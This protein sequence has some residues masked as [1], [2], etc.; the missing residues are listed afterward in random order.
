MTNQQLKTIRD[1][2]IKANPEKLGYC[3]RGGCYDD[4][5][6]LQKHQCPIGLASVLLA[7][8]ELDN[9]QIG[10]VDSSGQ[11]G[12]DT[13]QGDGVDW[14]GVCWNLRQDDLTLQSDECISFLAELFK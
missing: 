13:L 4:V 14:S 1:A 2:C 9:D 8:N 10:M 6:Q 7:I 5:C 12:H 3:Y 11:F